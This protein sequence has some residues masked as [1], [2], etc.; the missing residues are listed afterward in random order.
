MS[1]IVKKAVDVS[2]AP[3]KSLLGS[4][5]PAPPKMPKLAKVAQMVSPDDEEVKAAKKRAAA[6]QMARSGR[7]STI[8]SDQSGSLGG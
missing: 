2:T 1:N 4:V 3:I 8:L 5:L 7:Q 6:T